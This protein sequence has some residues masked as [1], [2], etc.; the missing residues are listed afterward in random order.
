MSLLVMVV[1]AYGFGP[2]LDEKLIHAASPR[3]TIL[4]IHAMLFAAWVMF[5]TVQSALV[6]TRAVS[7]R[8][9]TRRRRILG[10]P[11]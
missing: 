3:P 6:R 2:K 7:R 4:Y 9:P 11:L 10:A 8:S 1:V 5:Y